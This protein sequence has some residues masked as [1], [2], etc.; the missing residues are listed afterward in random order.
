MQKVLIAGAT[1]YLGRYVATEFKRQ[2]YL[3][4]VFR[5]GI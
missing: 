2:Q 3:G 4:I 1:G 5:P